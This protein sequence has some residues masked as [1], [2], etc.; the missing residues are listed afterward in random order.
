MVE[1]KK[2]DVFTLGWLDPRNQKILPA[3]VAFYNDEY[4][5]FQLKI[6]EEP[7]EKPYYLRASGYE[8]N[9]INYKMELIVKRRDGSFLKRVPVGLGEISKTTNGNIHVNYGSKFKT[10]VLFLNK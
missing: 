6:D 5:E 10:L 9:V 3:G 8:D 7:H 2:R 1:E 4:D